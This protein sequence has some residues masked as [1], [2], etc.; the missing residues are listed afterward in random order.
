MKSPTS[1]LPAPDA[2]APRLS[3]Q[4]G[5]RLVEERL[6]AWTQSP[7]P[8]LEE[9]AQRILG[10]G[11]KRFRPTLVLYSYLAN[12][13]NPFTKEVLD[14]AAAY[15]LIHT[16][17]LIHDD[18]VD[19]AD[20]RR[21]APSIHR[22]YG[23]SRAILIGDHLFA[24]ALQALPSLPGEVQVSM[25]HAA[26]LLGEGEAK[27]IELTKQGSATL[28][29]YFL[30]IAKKTASLL[31]SCTFAGAHLARS[32]HAEAFAEFGF[33]SGVA[34]QLIDDLL[35]V[36]GVT[37]I[38][39]KPVQLDLARGVPNAAVL[40]TLEADLRGKPQPVRLPHGT[41]EQLEAILQRMTEI[42]ADER[43]RRL[44]TM[45]ATRAL[46][47]LASVP[48]S[49]AKAALITEARAGLERIR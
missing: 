37:E 48:D 47:A 5:L 36:E 17:T 20:T 3:L 46:D 13:G 25:L 22:A 18:I 32:E 33:H 21:G 45:Y 29:D 30:V 19:D 28:E 27:E 34:F 31:E 15:E 12:G 14:A 43:V 38:T 41:Q 49:P 8:F 23:N 10:A 11:G 7:V 35:D 44:A 39:G 6:L 16:A 4:I 26:R 40:A 2:A 1:A 42:R 9:A 24:L